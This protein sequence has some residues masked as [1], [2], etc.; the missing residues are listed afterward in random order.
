MVARPFS[1][2][3]AARRIEPEKLEAH[4]LMALQSIRELRE[5]L[6]EAEIRAIERSLELGAQKEEVA[7]T[8]SVTR[9]GVDYKLRSKPAV[10]AP[11]AG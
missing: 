6:R 4:P 5:Y 11:D 8:L 1:P 2:Q 10:V 7:E 3:R 9:Q